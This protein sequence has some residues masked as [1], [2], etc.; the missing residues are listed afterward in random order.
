[1]RPKIPRPHVTRL[2]SIIVFQRVWNGT[3]DCRGMIGP[4]NIRIGER[5]KPELGLP[6]SSQVHEYFLLARTPTIIKP[7]HV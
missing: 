1:M 2:S 6:V 4:R 7:G 3:K 5:G